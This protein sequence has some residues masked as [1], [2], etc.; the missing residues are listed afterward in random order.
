MQDSTA[1]IVDVPEVIDGG[2]HVDDGHVWVHNLERFESKAN[3]VIKNLFS[4][5][6]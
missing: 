2:F 6:N 4:Y 1:I 3:L 5:K